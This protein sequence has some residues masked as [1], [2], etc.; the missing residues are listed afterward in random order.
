MRCTIKTHKVKLSRI[1][2]WV[3]NLA[4]VRC[5]VIPWPS[6]KSLGFARCWSGVRS[7]VG[8]IT[9]YTAEE[10][11]IR[12]KQLSSVPCAARDGCRIFWSWWLIL[13]YIYGCTYFWIVTYCVIITDHCY[14]DDVCLCRVW[15]VGWLVEFYGISTTIDYL[16]PNTGHICLCK[17]TFYKLTFYKLRF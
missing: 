16:I 7:P 15:L 13:I 6:G 14:V 10:I 12:S 1:T 2:P 17:L 11:Q 5:D 3:V 4:S 9:V 8:E